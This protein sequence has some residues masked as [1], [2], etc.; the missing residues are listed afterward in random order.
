MTTPDVRIF[1]PQLQAELDLVQRRGNNTN[2]AAVGDEEGLFIVA[3]NGRPWNGNAAPAQPLPT[4]VVL[5][6]A[7]EKTVAFAGLPYQV[8][9]RP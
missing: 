7:A 9:V 2:V 6:G 1:R 4:T 5:R 8:I 3:S